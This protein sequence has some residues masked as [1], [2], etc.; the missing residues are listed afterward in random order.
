VQTARGIK[1]NI[2]VARRGIIHA[3]I[4]SLHG[5]SERRWGHSRIFLTQ[6]ETHVACRPRR[7]AR[8]DRQESWAL[9]GLTRKF[10]AV[11]NRRQGCPAPL[12]QGEARPGTV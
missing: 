5:R 11:G 1:E 10:E 2:K 3:H 6:Q 12:H 9:K 8:K 7:S 4:N